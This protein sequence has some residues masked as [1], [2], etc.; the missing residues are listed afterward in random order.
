MNSKRCTEGNRLNLWISTS[1]LV[2]VAMALPLAG[3]GCN[4][5]ASATPD[6][7][8][9]QTS[10]VVVGHPEKKEL[11]RE[12][13]QPGFLRPYEQTPIYTKIAGFSK[14][15]KVDRGDRVKKDELLVELYLPEVEQQLRVKAAKILQ[16]KADH[17]QAKEAAKAAKAAE[18]AAQ[19][20]VDAK[21]ASIHSAEAQVRRWQAEDVRSRKLLQRGT[22]DQQ[23]V[24]EI[25]HQLQASQAFLEEAKAKHASAKASHIQASAQFGKAEADVE[26]ADANVKVA[27]ADHDQWKDWLSY[28][29]IRAPYAGVITMRH[30]H[31]GHFLQPNNSGNTTKMAEPLFMIMRTD[32]MR[33]TVE[34]PE[35]DAN[36]I[37]KGDKARVRFQTKNGGVPELWA[38]VTRDSFALDDHSRTLTVEVYL[39]NNDGK[40]LPFT[41]ANVTIFT[42]L[43]NVWS[44]PSEAILNDILEDGDRSYCFLVEDGKAHKAFLDIGARG[45]EGIQVLRKQRPGGQWEPITGKERVVVVNPKGLLEGQ[46]VQIKKTE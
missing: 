3:V 10:L 7:T 4:Q 9:E 16:T 33:L 22:F 23:T 37:R 30:V 31:T 12:I 45:D 39:D 2:L 38:T 20:E 8:A 25:F 19:A 35:L 5:G 11:T 14:E 34:V 41:Y 27:E 15:P 40:L 24:D 1:G 36:L 18:D 43:P 46:E 42:K 44:L 21:L 6:E 17:K 32:I 28:K 13:D 26:V 29:E